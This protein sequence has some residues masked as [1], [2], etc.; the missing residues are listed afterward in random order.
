MVNHGKKH[1]RSL[2]LCEKL[3]RVMITC[4]VMLLIAT[5]TLYAYHHGYTSLSSSS[6]PSLPS[7]SNSMS[8]GPIQVKGAIIVT[9]VGNYLKEYFEWSCRT[10][11]LS[12]PSYDML[13]F[14]EDNHLLNNVKCGNNVKF[15][16]I[17]K[18]GFA[19]IIVK[20]MFK[21]KATS[22][23]IESMI[24]LVASVI[25][26]VP[27]YMVE[28]KPMSG[29]L[30]A[31]YLK[32]YSHWSYTDA[33]IIWG[34]LNDWIQY[35]DLCNYDVITIAK[36]H[37]AGRLFMRG[38]FALHKNIDRVNFLWKELEY[39]S[40]VS[41]S[42]RMEGASILLKEGKL[43][44][45]IIYGKHF[46]SAEGFYS[47]VVFNSNVSIKVLGLGF[48][49]FST[50]PVVLNN[51]LLIR[52]SF[53]STKECIESSKKDKVIVSNNN[54]NKQVQAYHDPKI[55]HMNWLPKSVRYCLAQADNRNEGH[56]Q[57]LKVGESFSVNGSWYIN[58]D[59]NNDIS[60]KTARQAAFFHFR[61]WDDFGSSGIMTKWSNDSNIMNTCM[62]LYVRSD[63]I[64]VFEPCLDA[65]SKDEFT[66]SRL[67]QVLETVHNGTKVTNDKTKQIMKKRKRKIS[68]KHN[69]KG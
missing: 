53:T 41:F 27:R 36:S 46:H 23:P 64:M 37:D 21:N 62:I 12:S 43:S 4:N 44:V 11:Q 20:E 56:L 45:D 29:S 1:K 14:H 16:N 5:I 31:S 59:N 52:C 68:Q 61:H 57:I 50:K 33:D 47:T 40:A 69:Q 15:I 19:S 26:K 13:I 3:T 55:C 9:L 7:S 49:D 28:I 25:E 39:F 48:D 66:K 60:R 42:S 58:P 24:D 17:G 67:R 38:Q 51:G 30:F 10:I 32:D 65:L 22:S 35:D 63:N 54:N 6:S 34:N 18:K 2:S 8:K